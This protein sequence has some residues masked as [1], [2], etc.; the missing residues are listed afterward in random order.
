MRWL[1][2]TVLCRRGRRCANLQVEAIPDFSELAELGLPVPGAGAVLHGVYT[3]GSCG[4]TYHT[5]ILLGE[6]GDFTQL[7][8]ERMKV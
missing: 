7:E 8:P 6:H 1:R 2:W 3:C 4:T 5:Q